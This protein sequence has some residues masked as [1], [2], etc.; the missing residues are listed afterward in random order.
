MR[1][2]RARDARRP[3]KGTTH[4]HTH[5]GLLRCARHSPQLTDVL[6]GRR[7]RTDSESG[8]RAQKAPKSKVACKRSFRIARSCERW[9]A[10]GMEVCGLS[11]HGG[12][13]TIAHAVRRVGALDFSV[14]L[15]VL[16]V[17][18]RQRKRCAAF[19]GAARACRPGRKKIHLPPHKKLDNSTFAFFPMKSAPNAICN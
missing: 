14:I 15:T 9:C 17:G 10:C 16:S 1:V 3:H 2:L 12:R 5:G 19:M 11:V 4:A 7:L 8:G 13:V 18:T 6:C